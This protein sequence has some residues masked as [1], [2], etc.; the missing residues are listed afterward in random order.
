MSSSSRPIDEVYA[1]LSLDDDDD[2][3]DVEF[4]VDDVVGEVKGLEFAA[5]G[6]L[7]SDQPFEFP[8]VCDTM[9]GVWRPGKGVT[10]MELQHNLFLF[11]F[12]HEFDL[13]RVLEDGPWASV[14]RYIH[15]SENPSLLLV[16]IP[17]DGTNYHTWSRAMKM[18]LLS[19]NKLG[20][21][22]G[23]V[24]APEITDANYITWQRANNMVLSWLLHSMIPVIAQSILWLDTA[25]E[26]WDDLK[27]RFCQED[28]FRISDVQAE[29][30]NIKQGDLSV[31]A[32]FTKFKLLWDE[33][34]SLK[35]LLTCTCTPRCKCGCLDRIKEHHQMEQVTTFLRG[36]SENYAGVK[37]QIM[38]MTPLPMVGKACSLVQQQERQIF[39]GG[40]GAL[41]LANG[42]EVVQSAFLA[43]TTQAGNINMGAST[44]Q[45]KIG[46]SNKKPIC[47]FCGFTGHTMDKCYKFHGYPPGWK[48]K[49]KQNVSCQDI[50]SPINQPTSHIP[51]EQLNTPLDDKLPS[52]VAAGDI[53]R[54]A[55]ASFTS[56][57]P[58]VQDGKHFVSCQSLT[59]IIDI[60]ATDHIVNNVTYF[61]D[62]NEVREIYVMLPDGN[63]AMVTHAARDRKMIGLAE[64]RDG[65]YRFLMPDDE[66]LQGVVEESS[67]GGGNFSSPN[68]A[69]FLGNFSSPGGSYSLSPEYQQLGDNF[70]VKNSSSSYM[71]SNGQDDRMPYD[72]S[73]PAHDGEP[74]DSGGQL[75]MESQLTVGDPCVQM[76]V[77]HK[78]WYSHIMQK[79][80]Q[81]SSV[82]LVQGTPH[83]ISKVVAYDHLSS[84]HKNFV[85]ASSCVIEPTSYNE[86]VKHECWREAMRAELEAL[87]VNKT[88]VL[89]D[90]LLQNN[91]LVNLLVLKRVA[92]NQSHLAVEL[93]HSEFWIQVHNLPIGFMSLRVAEAVGNHVGRFVKADHNN[94]DGSWKSFM[95]VRVEANGV[96]SEREG[97]VCIDGVLQWQKP[98][99]GRW[100][101]NVDAAFGVWV[102]SGGSWDWGGV[103]LV[104]GCGSAGLIVEMDAK[105]V[106]DALHGFAGESYFDLIL[107]DI[108][109]I[110]ATIDDLHFSVVKCS[111]NQVVHLLVRESVSLSEPTFWF[112]V[113][114]LL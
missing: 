88:W 89:T 29:I 53:N 19:K 8:I 64:E 82:L 70:G 27:E 55:N 106:F 9:A 5:V 99:M 49:N 20:F 39:H 45:R 108:K 2:G 105:E 80:F 1:S 17:L 67:M 11:Q 96:G 103:E 56:F 47:S 111:A 73:S 12:Y 112:D 28:V 51:R 10:I 44:T 114:P 110:A 97:V 52:T 15:S 68:N 59:W 107:D 74:T 71:S 4:G 76:I 109:V 58:N 16:T 92:A 46:N 93:R 87:D 36:L 85:L 86:A 75:M 54:Q 104:K 102:F 78:A 14:L 32:Y 6:R 66:P 35:P 48:G 63:R 69:H 3:G 30:Y 22:D 72:S 98:V 42:E 62:S 7:L 38:L 81:H 25:K 13:Q 18:T 113:L 100:K 37:S 40:L 91:P 77:I 79:L 50:P 26:V 83:C 21:V 60:G 41:V 57:K 94:F 61:L 33:L 90:L 101:L 23:S 24:M 43:R 84:S 34:L 65:L 31:S 95:R